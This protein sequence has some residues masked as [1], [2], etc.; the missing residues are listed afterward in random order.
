MREEFYRAR[1]EA[2]FSLGQRTG[3]LETYF[4]MQ[5]FLSEQQGLDPSGESAQLY[6]RLLGDD[7]ESSWGLLSG[8]ESDC[9]SEEP[10]DVWGRDE[11]ARHKRNG[12]DHDGGRE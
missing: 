1:M 12:S 2:Q 10:D 6:Q 11:G 7:Q 5:R 3:A 9:E 4:K 8:V